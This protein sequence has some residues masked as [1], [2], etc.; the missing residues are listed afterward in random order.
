MVGLIVAVVF[1]A[2]LVKLLESVREEQNQVV[3]SSFMEVFAS[4]KEKEEE[5]K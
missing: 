5:E 3:T 4:M 2:V 1:V